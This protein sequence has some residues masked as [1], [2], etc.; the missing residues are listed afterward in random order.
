MFEKLRALLGLRSGYM[1]W[2]ELLERLREVEN[3]KKLLLEENKELKGM[4]K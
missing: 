1:T 4:F 2:E 3:M